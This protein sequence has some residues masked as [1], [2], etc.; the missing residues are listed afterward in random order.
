MTKINP[1]LCA[2]ITMHR[3]RGATVVLADGSERERSDEVLVFVPTHRDPGLDATEFERVQVSFDH[4]SEPT[5]VERITVIGRRAEHRQINNIPLWLAQDTFGNDDVHEGGPLLRSMWGQ[6][7]EFA[8][9]M[10]KELDDNNTL[11][12]G[13]LDKSAFGKVR[14]LEVRA[15]RV[16][17][18]IR[19]RM[20]ITLST[21][22]RI[23]VMLRPDAEYTIE[24]A[25]DAQVALCERISGGEF[26]PVTSV[27]FDYGVI[28]TDVSGE[29]AETLSFTSGNVVLFCTSEPA[30]NETVTWEPLPVLENMQLTWLAEGTIRDSLLHEIA[31]AETDEQRAE[32][33]SIL[34]GLDAAEAQG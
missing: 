17:M 27:K 24:D 5:F 1:F 4:E 28:V 25:T 30:L 6:S 3:F 21:G 18:L 23:A 8:K 19:N 12:R 32:V 15:D 33:Q 22:T 9:M 29:G 7:E 34:D 31:V 20:Q 14:V 26:K 11:L 16:G 13:D 2:A 10:G